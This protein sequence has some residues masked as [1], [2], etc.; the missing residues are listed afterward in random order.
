MERMIGDYTEHQMRDFRR[1]DA[2][3]RMS[4][5]LEAYARCM[6]SAV[7]ATLNGDERSAR[8]LRCDARATLAHDY[9]DLLKMVEAAT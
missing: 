4:G 8:L 7:R 5:A 6:Q 9:P 1:R 2:A 3:G